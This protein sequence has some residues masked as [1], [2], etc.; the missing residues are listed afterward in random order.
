MDEPA[1]LRH[2]RDFTKLW[3]GQTVSIFG[4]LITRTALPFAAILTLHASPIELGLLT[5]ADVAPGILAGLIAGAWIDR[6]RRRPLM[7]ASDLGRALL[8]ASIPLAYLLG[9]LHITQLYLVALLAGTLTTVFEV[10]YLAYLPSV[11][12]RQ[13]LL[14]GNSRLAASASVAESASFGLGGWLVQL[15]SAPLAI[16]IDAVSFLWSAASLALIR[17]PEPPPLPEGERQGMR[18]EIG[19]GLRLVLHDRPLRVLAGSAALLTLS[20]GIGSA[21]FMLYVTRNLGFEPGVLGMIFAVGGVSSLLAAALTP[22]LTARLGETRA[23]AVGLALT[24]LGSLLVVLAPGATILG[25]AFLVGQQLV[26]DSGATLFLVN[27]K[28]LVQ[29]AAP[30]R[31]LGRVTATVRFGTVVTML[32]GSLAGGLLGELLGVRAAY[33]LSPLV[34]LTAAIWLARL[35]A[36]LHAR[37]AVAAGDYE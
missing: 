27:N 30:D 1:S 21:L 22:R 4:S 31:L 29:A 2:N 5:A 14:E 28:S 19:E 12:G 24:A 26:G 15:F 8:L 33:A 7:I 37:Q 3:T 20:M 10:A 18:R 16:A 23:M 6:L 25:V 17:A 9:V 34:T 11:V 36:T 32:A 13:Q 35:P